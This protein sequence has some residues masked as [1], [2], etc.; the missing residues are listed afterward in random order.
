MGFNFV[1]AGQGMVLANSHRG[2]SHCY[3]ENTMPAFEAALAAGTHSIEL[4]IHMTKDE[5]LVVH[6]DFTIDR[7]S[8]GTGYV[9]QMTL[10][11]LRQYD[12][13]IKFDPKFAG[14]PIPE[15]REV[16]LWAVANHVGVVL[17]VKQ[18]LNHQRCAEVLA[19]TLLETNAVDNVL[20]LAFDHVLINRVKTILPQVKLQV[21][22]LARYNKQL[23]ATLGSNAASACVEYHYVHRDDLSAYKKAGLSVRLYLHES[24]PG[25][26]ITQVYNEKYGIDAESEIIEWLRE[27]LIDMLS[28]DD[29]PYLCK[30]I[31]KAG[32]KPY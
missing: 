18:K 4:D 19:D 22:T 1:V 29:I 11:E 32:K 3:P 21:V 26:E 31:E 13:G 17:E 10:A 24:P 12:Y 28:H 14:T 5:K 30:L 20:L 8:T 2:Y 25:R 16:L 15:L 9:E 7:V 27:G 23:E 6:H